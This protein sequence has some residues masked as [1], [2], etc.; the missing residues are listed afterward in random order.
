[1]RELARFKFFLKRKEMQFRSIA[2]DK[3]ALKRNLRKNLKSLVFEADSV[4]LKRQ[5]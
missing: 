3:S 4:K 2:I 1:M 5:K